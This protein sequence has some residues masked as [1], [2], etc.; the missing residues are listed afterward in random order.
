MSSIFQHHDT[1]QILKVLQQGPSTEGYEQAFS[2]LHKNFNSR[3]I[4]HLV[5]SHRVSVQDAEDIV[6]QAFINLHLKSKNKK[7]DIQTS[8][9][10]YFRGTINN[11]TVDWLKKKKRILQLTEILAGKMQ[12]NTGPVCIGRKLA[13]EVDRILAQLSNPKCCALLFPEDPDQAMEQLAKK[14]GY[15]NAAS[16]SV[17]RTKCKKELIEILKKEGYIV[18]QPHDSAK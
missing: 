18:K 9:W 4:K 16:A 7:L 1:R 17:M 15:S 13:E 3:A 14:L 8:F 6:Q 11:L 2:R 10:G 12:W 5:K